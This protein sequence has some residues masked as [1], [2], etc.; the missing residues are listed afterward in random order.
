MCYIIIV[1]S[2]PKLSEN[3]TR[4]RQHADLV[5]ARHNSLNNG[6][7]LECDHKHIIIISIVHHTV[8]CAQRN[9]Y[10]VHSYMNTWKK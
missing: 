7:L 3:S 2:R 8:N 5:A 6:V 1:A 9:I 4:R 10:I